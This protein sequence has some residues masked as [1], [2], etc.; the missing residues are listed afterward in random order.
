M[1]RCSGNDYIFS[2]ELTPGEAQI[3]YCHEKDEECS[4]T[5]ILTS[6]G[7][8]CAVS[9]ELNI[10]K[11]GD[12]SNVIKAGW[13]KKADNKKIFFIP[14][15]VEEYNRIC[16]IRDKKRN[17][18]D[19]FISKV[20]NVFLE[21]VIGAAM[22]RSIQTFDHVHASIHWVLTV[23]DIWSANF[24]ISVKQL[25]TTYPVKDI[26]AIMVV[27]QSDAL[28]RYMQSPQYGFTFINGEYYILCFFKPDHQ[29]IILGYEVGP[30]LKG[31][32]GISSY[33]LTDTIDLKLESIEL[34]NFLKLV[35]HG[36]TKEA[37]RYNV[38]I[39]YI[40]QRFWHI[41]SDSDEMTLDTFLKRH[42]AE[43]FPDIKD[44]FFTD[45]TSLLKKI[46]WKDIK[47]NINYMESQY[48]TTIRNNIK[49]LTEK[50]HNCKLIVLEAQAVYQEHI[51]DMVNH[52]SPSLKARFQDAGR[53]VLFRYVN[54]ASQLN[55]DQLRIDNYIPQIVSND[56]QKTI[57]EKETLYIDISRK[58][59]TAIF[60]DSK[61]KTT[62]I[63]DTIEA[64]NN[65]FSFDDCFTVKLP[66]YDSKLGSVDIT[67][68]FLEMIESDQEHLF[69]KLKTNDSTE[70]TIT[71][72]NGSAST[73]KSNTQKFTKSTNGITKKNGVMRQHDQQIISYYYEQ[74]LIIY[75][76]Q[77]YTHIT[78]Y[79]QSKEYIGNSTH[80][81]C[82]IAI[83][84]N[85]LELLNIQYDELNDKIRS[86]K[87]NIKQTSDFKLLQRE[88]LSA[89]YC[90]NQLK[91]YE[92][93]EEHLDY[94]LHSLQVQLN[95]TY[96][97]LSLHSILP[98]SKNIKL[99]NNET[100]LTI[101][102][103][104]IPFDFMEAM[105]ELIW[106]HIQSLDICPIKTCK[107]H[108]ISD[109]S[110]QL[111][112]FTQ[113]MECFSQYFI[114]EFTFNNKQGRADWYNNKKIRMNAQCNCIFNMSSIDIFDIS[115]QPVIHKVTETIYASIVNVCL[116]GEYKVSHIS[117]MGS[118]MDKKM[119]NFTYNELIRRLKVSIEYQRKYHNNIRIEWMDKDISTAISEGFS[120]IMQNPNSG[121]LEQVFAGS[122]K[123]SSMYEIYYD[124]RKKQNVPLEEQQILVFQ[125]QRITESIR[126]KGISSV[127]YMEEV[128]L[129]SNIYCQ[130]VEKNEDSTKFITTI[131]SYELDNSYPLVIRVFP[132]MYF[133]TIT[134]HANAD[135]K[136]N[137]IVPDKVVLRENFMFSIY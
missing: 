38:N 137:A 53:H 39:D 64:N 55:Q 94:P 92:Q 124:H 9:D 99:P 71:L 118:L 97:N 90:M 43:Y 114:N 87:N 49:E 7:T 62:I 78:H 65:C 105:G 82:F 21:M 25:L 134:I 76:E 107:Q 132:S 11:Y 18:Y 85:I 125:G 58:K 44:S 112:L 75:I 130:V 88:Q 106:N 73:T 34:N 50:H 5:S 13:D 29:I 26:D 70:K 24:A 135:G 42:K 79:L 83:E 12:L 122:Y 15:I 80:P 133:I 136:G 23:P 20:F 4:G 131:N 126:E 46:T 30:P 119:C 59:N 51:Q 41:Y 36:D 128:L 116:F 74:L 121:L 108:N 93:L 52:V 66:D 54:G 63:N 60:V 115:I 77:L 32:K 103:K 96:I 98:L 16:Q 101:K 84:N 40:I 1:P 68:R 35:F 48:F 113:F 57:T 89:V 22:H 117:I 28:L 100:T 69:Q 3:V 45:K 33:R 127:Y 19:V 86:H 31:L 120:L 6:T 14:C 2:I 123:M 27:T 8:A 56:T 17:R 72:T 67:L 110:N 111:C 104:V 37:E 129:F 91:C 47:A 95:P 102:R 81:V 10:L 61:K 109:Y